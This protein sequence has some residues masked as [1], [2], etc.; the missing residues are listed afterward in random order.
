M[1]FLLALI[2]VGICKA[3]NDYD[4]LECFE[5]NTKKVC[6]QIVDGKPVSFCCE[7]TDKTGNCNCEKGFGELYGCGNTLLCGSDDV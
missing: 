6:S 7:T 3:L 2:I 4:C 5:T 1:R